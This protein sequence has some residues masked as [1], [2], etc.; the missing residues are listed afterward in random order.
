[1]FW[2]HLNAATLQALKEERCQYD[3][4]QQCHPTLYMNQAVCYCMFTIQKRTVQ[5]RKE[6]STSPWQQGL[7][8]TV[9]LDHLIVQQEQSVVLDSSTHT[10]YPLHQCDSPEQDLD[11]TSW[12]QR[13]GGLSFS[14]VALSSA[15]AT[16]FTSTSN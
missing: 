9:G 8:R 10:C 5:V 12:V 4:L 13:T 3:T 1:M 7:A 15:M 6:E 16:V 2:H 14:F 11:L